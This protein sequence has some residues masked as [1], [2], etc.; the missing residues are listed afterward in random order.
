MAKKPTSVRAAQKA[1]SLYFYDKK[2]GVKKLAVTAEQ[3]TAWKKKN[4]GKYEGNALTAWANNKGKDIGVTKSLRPKLRPKKKVES[5]KGILGL[6]SRLDEPG[7]NFATDPKDRKLALTDFQKAK[8]EAKK[9]AD[10]ADRELKEVQ[11]EIKAEIRLREQKAAKKRE[12]IRSAEELL[13]DT[14]PKNTRTPEEFQA[15]RKG[16]RNQPVRKVSSA[17]SVSDTEGL[18]KGNIIPGDEE[19]A[20]DVLAVRRARQKLVNKKN[21]GGMIKK[22][23]YMGGG[24]TKKKVMTYNMGGMIKA[25]INNLKKGR[26]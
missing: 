7:M 6:E 10:A 14:A 13:K 24:M 16:K 12:A 5:T 1:G 15:G 20:L 25:Q 3:L 11:A 21:K 23:G 9:E 26:S 19:N 2:S 17:R 8:I 4:K 22:S 18:T